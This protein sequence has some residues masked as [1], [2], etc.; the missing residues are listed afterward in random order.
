MYP[1]ESHA[2]LESS[3]LFPTMHIALHNYSLHIQ[4]VHSVEAACP[5]RIINMRTAMLGYTPSLAL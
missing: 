2:L 5:V 3:G 4:K 1:Y